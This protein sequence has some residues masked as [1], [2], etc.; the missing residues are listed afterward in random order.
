MLSVLLGN[1]VKEE[2]DAVHR[3]IKL[4]FAEHYNEFVVGVFVD[5]E[6]AE[7]HVGEV[8]LRAVLGLG[9]GVFFGDEV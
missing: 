4:F 6:G 1:G 9:F 2:V 5:V 8:S 3:F 7:T